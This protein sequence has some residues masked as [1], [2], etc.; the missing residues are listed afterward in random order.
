MTKMA[1][2]HALFVKAQAETNSWILCASWMYIILENTLK[3]NHSVMFSHLPE[4]QFAATDFAAMTIKEQE[5]LANRSTT[6]GECFPCECLA[7]D[8]L[9]SL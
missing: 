1:V 9:S 5:S 4:S 3:M 2:F 8:L 7:L 6:F